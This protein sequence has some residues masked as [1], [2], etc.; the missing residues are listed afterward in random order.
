MRITCWWV[1][2]MLPVWADKQG[3]QGMLSID[4]FAVLE[5]EGSPYTRF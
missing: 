1:K 2:V 4:G 5:E 3:H